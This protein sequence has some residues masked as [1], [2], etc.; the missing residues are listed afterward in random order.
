MSNEVNDKFWESWQGAT[1]I[2]GEIKRAKRREGG[3]DFEFVSDRPDDHG[4]S[5][6]LPLPIE[7]KYTVGVDLVGFSKRPTE[8]QLFLT[9][10][11]FSRLDSTVRLL[12]QVKW[13]G[14]KDPSAII[15]TGDGALLVFESFNQAF[16]AILAL[17]MFL[18]DV[19]LGRWCRVSPDLD[20]TWPA[21][22]LPFEIRYALAQGELIP[23]RDP[24][25]QLNYVGDGLVRVARLLG[26]SKGSHL[27]I[28]E[29]VMTERY[30]VG[31]INA[32]NEEECSWSQ[33]LHVSGRLER[34][35]KSG[36]YGFYNVFGFFASTGL[37]RRLADTCCNDE[38]RE[39]SHG[40]ANTSQRYEIGSHD[41]STIP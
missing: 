7:Q 36:T 11:L 21:P 41:V 39:W 4:V 23:I 27:L 30:N 34:R 38:K 33:E 6:N 26:A 28:D 9:A 29:R 37:M 31:G 2:E 32:Q 3:I 35:L 8:G 19:M 10:V 40:V 22:A 18:S 16:A 12:R 25:G 14:H 13:L 5:Y 17:H 15:P 24:N 20:K 1:S